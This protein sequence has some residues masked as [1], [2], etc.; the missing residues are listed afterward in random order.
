MEKSPLDATSL[1][2]TVFSRPRLRSFLSQPLSQHIGKLLL[3]SGW[4]KTSQP[5]SWKNIR[6][7]ASP[8]TY[9]FF[10]TSVAKF[11]FPAPVSNTYS[12]FRGA[13]AGNAPRGGGCPLMSPPPFICPGKRKTEAWRQHRDMHWNI[14]VPEQCKR[15][16]ITLIWAAALNPSINISKKMSISTRYHASAFIHT[17]RPG[18]PIK[19][20]SGVWLSARMN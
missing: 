11:S 13:S 15:F 18:F 16:I 9:C 4:Q 10:K 6:H 14:Y 19:S 17:S 20:V 7:S 1:V 5:R 3:T 2:P 12:P 8:R